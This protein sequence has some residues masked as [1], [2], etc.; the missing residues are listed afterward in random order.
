M[1]AKVKSRSS[2]DWE[3]AGPTNIGGRISDLEMPA[4]DI[5]TIYA[6][7]ASGGIFK[8]TDQGDSWVPI[9]EEA[10]SLSIGDIALAPGNNDIIYVGTGESNAGGGSL[11]Y[12]GFGVYRSDD[13]GGSWQHV[14]LEDAGSIGR[15]V[16]DPQNEDRVFVA[17]MGDLFGNDADRGV[18]RTLDGGTN[19]EQVLYVSDSTGAIDLV[20]HPDDP[21]VLLAGM[22]ERI[23]RPAYR[24]YEGLTTGI[25]K[26][27]DG[28]D[29]WTEIT[30]GLP[31]GLIGRIGLAFAP[32]NP[33]KV[34]AVIANLN[35]LEGVYVSD[36][37]GDN[38]S[39]LSG[40]GLGTVPFMWWF[41]RII[42]DPNDEDVL[43]TTS[44]DMYK[45]TNGGNSWFNISEDETH[46]D[47]HALVAHPLNSNL[48][49]SGNDGG[50]YVS[51]NGGNTWDFKNTLPIT[52]F[53]TCEIDFQQPERLYGG[54]QDNGTNRTLTGNLDDWAFFLWGDGFVVQVDPDNSNRLYAEYQ[55]GNLFR[56]DNNGNNLTNITPNTPIA[57][58]NTPYVLYPGNAD[59]L[60]YGSNRIYRSNNAG[61]FWQIIS[62]D[63][64]KGPHAGNLSYGTVTTMDIST[65]NDE[66]IYAGTD[67]GNVWVSQDDGDNW[68][69]ISDDL[70]NRWVT[71]V[72]ADPHDEAS[73]Y[74]TFSGYRY[75]ESLS[76]VFKT[77]D[78][79]VTW[80]NL[81]DGL[82]EVPINDIAVDPLYQG[83]LYIAT[84]FGVFASYDDGFSWELLGLSLP[85][86]PVIDL[87][88]HPEEGFLLAATYGRSMYKI[89][90]RDP[91]AIEQ[92]KLEHGSFKLY[93][94]PVKANLTLEWNQQLASPVR[95]E[96]L[97]VNGRLLEVILDEERS[98]GLQILN[99]QAG[100][101]MGGSYLLNLRMGEKRN[102][103]IKMLKL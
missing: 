21:D 30:Q 67:D 29:S 27:T 60:L 98:A 65:L 82:P 44:L 16:V 53:Y 23:R 8:S 88:L 42:V 59:K 51:Q 13:A 103:I 43:F 84:D 100:H 96:L 4:D 33:D 31:G 46:V 72:H 17:A 87:D 49:V 54:T 68:E 26:S 15:V 48:V 10:A 6:G 75:Y 47:Q 32:S 19:W 40:A 62:P 28:G 36:D 1:R 56:S 80:E 92:A 101:L 14:G 99:W 3:F 74:V 11:A 64:T 66:I 41:G 20:M 35:G 90:I 102:E 70:P 55:Y 2:E 81:A 76:H 57:N 5:N 63:L 34:Y 95:L 71:K 22:W 39:Q 9:F 50:V 45:S 37:F 38:W 94:N 89:N 7:A 85:N 97:D 78:Y 73:A 69:L 58:W 93:P 79:G 86:V 24:Q 25:Y 91:L 77:S 83:F 61:G 12:D 18:Y 52:Q